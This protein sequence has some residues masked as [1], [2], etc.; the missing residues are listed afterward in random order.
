MNGRSVPAIYCN[1]FS[2]SR[3]R[4]DIVRLTFSEVVEGETHARAAVAMSLS[5]ADELARIL[6]DVCRAIQDK[7]Q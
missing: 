4:E 1:R 7:K 6:A 5:D 3:N 2:V